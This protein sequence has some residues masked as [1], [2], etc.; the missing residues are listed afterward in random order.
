MSRGGQQRG[1]ADNRSGGDEGSTAH[2]GSFRSL[3]GAARFVP[4]WPTSQHTSG[5]G[6]APA[7]RMAAPVCCDCQVRPP[8]V[9]RSTAAAWTPGANRHRTPAS[10]DGTSNVR[11][12][13]DSLSAP[14]AV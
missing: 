13:T 1:D 5:E 4:F 9:V 11:T 3:N 8:S 7:S 10:D 14:A 12:A 2:S 6:E